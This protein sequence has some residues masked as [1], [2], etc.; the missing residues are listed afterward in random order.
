MDI[1]SNHI[2]E[3]TY[4][5][6]YINQSTMPLLLTTVP[7][8][9]SELH[10]QTHLASRRYIRWPTVNLIFIILMNNI[11]TCLLKADGK[12]TAQ[13]ICMWQSRQYKMRS[14]LAVEQCVCYIQMHIYK[15]TSS[16][17]AWFITSC[18]IFKNLVRQWARDQ[19]QHFNSSSALKSS[20]CFEVKNNKYS[21]AVRKVSYVTEG[22]RRSTIWLSF[23]ISLCFYNWKG[24]DELSVHS[25]FHSPLKR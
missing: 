8:T 11:E 2:L 20:S 22:N 17:W 23:G 25:P 9:V 3:S 1:I 19:L 7:P 6:V 15:C 4:A 18:V 24:H 5:V 14:T 13:M 12:V 10:L 21:E 16:G